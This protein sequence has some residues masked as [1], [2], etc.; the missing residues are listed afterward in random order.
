MWA[1]LG[2][3]KT[4][5]FIKENPRRASKENFTINNQAKIGKRG[6]K[7]FGGFKRKILSD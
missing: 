2:A 4:L 5:N 7:S 6:D 1:D 3:L